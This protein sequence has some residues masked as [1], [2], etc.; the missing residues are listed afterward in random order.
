MVSSPVVKRAPNGRISVACSASAYLNAGKHSTCVASTD[1][2]HNESTSQVPSQA[3][4]NRAKSATR[5]AVRASKQS[6]D[7]QSR[8]GN[9]ALATQANC[10]KDTDSAPQTPFRRALRTALARSCAATTGNDSSALV[11]RNERAAAGQDTSSPAVGLL[12]C[13]QT[14][15]LVRCSLRI[16]AAHATHIPGR[17]AC[18]H[19]P[20]NG[21]RHDQ[22]SAATNIER[23]CVQVA[24][25]QGGKARQAAN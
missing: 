7:A 24:K 21:N 19:A 6:R 1:T 16:E 17:P 8:T 20:T 2:Q 13:M 5:S 4:G 12:A 14:R 22:P 9:T 18:N 25:W 15:N 11:P 10:S 3:P 23:S